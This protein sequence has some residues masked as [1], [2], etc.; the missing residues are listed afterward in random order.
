[1]TITTFNTYTKRKSANLEIL[2]QKQGKMIHIIF[3]DSYLELL[4]RVIAP[5]SPPTATVSLNT[6]IV[7][8][9]KWAGSHIIFSPLGYSR[10]PCTSKVG[11]FDKI[12]GWSVSGQILI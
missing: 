3:C 2:C 11:M 9:R 10:K 5:L 7:A 6:V 1:M 4:I 12:L 8:P